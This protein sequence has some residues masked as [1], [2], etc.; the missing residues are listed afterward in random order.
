MFDDGP[1]TEEEADDSD[2]EE[3]V[4][5]SLISTDSDE[6]LFVNNNRQG[7]MDDSDEEF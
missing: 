2:D 3:L 5:G 4:E 6:G 7:F 1:R